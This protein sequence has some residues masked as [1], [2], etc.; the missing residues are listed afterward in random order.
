MPTVKYA[1]GRNASLRRQWKMPGWPLT[2]TIRAKR[3]EFVLG[4]S[5]PEL[6]TVFHVY[7]PFS[8]LVIGRSEILSYSADNPK[9]FGGQFIFSFK[10]P[11]KWKSLNKATSKFPIQA[12][13]QRSA[14]EMRWCSKRVILSSKPAIVTSLG[15]TGLISQ[16]EYEIS[17]NELSKSDRYH[18]V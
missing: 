9:L 12:V 5:S 7:N 1:K 15:W 17:S 14:F 2:K 8:I 11:R 10:W 4:R 6:G 13:Q 3:Q 18:I 16:P